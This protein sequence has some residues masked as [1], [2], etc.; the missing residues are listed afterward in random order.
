MADPW[1]KSLTCNERGLFLQLLIICKETLDNGHVIVSSFTELGARCGLHRTTC[2]KIAAK[3]DT[4]R[5]VVMSKDRHGSIDIYI[6]KY[7]EYQEMTTK[8]VVKMMRSNVEK[9]TPKSRQPEQSKPK[10][11]K[12]NHSITRKPRE[13]KPEDPRK[14]IQ[15]LNDY[16]EKNQTTITAFARPYRNISENECPSW[17]WDWIK[18]EIDK[19]RGWIIAKSSD[20][21]KY[22]ITRPGGFMSGWLKRAAGSLTGADEEAERKENQQVRGSSDLLPLEDILDKIDGKNIKTV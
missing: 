4:T 17:F 16:I 18:F 7:L 9:P 22:K 19:M 10:Q 5:T 3:F 12:P 1:F 20:D 11:T 15:V 8:D 2:A 6:P 13:P 14:P 21:P